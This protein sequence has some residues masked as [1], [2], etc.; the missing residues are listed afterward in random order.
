MREDTQISGCHS[1]I[2]RSQD[3]R[4]IAQDCELQA[5]IP[6]AGTSRLV[7]T[8]LRRSLWPRAVS[9]V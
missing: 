2:F 9:E 6:C 3:H 7:S 8:C 4:I 5:M 1:I